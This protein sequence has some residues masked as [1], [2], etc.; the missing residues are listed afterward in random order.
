MGV[1]AKWGRFPICPEMSRFVPVCYL[2]GHFLRGGNGRGGFHTRVRGTMFVRN[3][4]V[5]PGPSRKCDITFFV[6]GRPKSARQSRDSTVAARSVQ[7]VTVP[8]SRVSRECRSPGLRSPPF[9]N[10]RSIVLLGAQNGDKSGQNSTNGLSSIEAKFC[11][12]RAHRALVIVLWS[13]QPLWLPH[14][15]KQNSISK[16]QS[17]SQRKPYHRRPQKT[18]YIKPYPLTPKNYYFRKDILK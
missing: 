14:A 4:A 10:A 1:D 12:E 8:S 18:T 5:T 2:F 9:K 11:R 7:S 16:P 13:R 3:G 15:F 17:W 6:K